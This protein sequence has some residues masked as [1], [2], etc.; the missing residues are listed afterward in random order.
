MAAPRLWTPRHGYS[1]LL[2]VPNLEG[3][4]Q[5]P[6]EPEPDSPVPPNRAQ[7]RAMLRAQRRGAPPQPSRGGGVR[8]RGQARKRARAARKANRQ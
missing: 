5:R 7:R 6:P 2:A 3:L 8:K 1:G 4:Y